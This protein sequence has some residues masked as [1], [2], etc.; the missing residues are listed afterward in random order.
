MGGKICTADIS[1][2]CH[3]AALTL[4]QPVPHPQQPTA[5]VPLAFFCVSSTNVTIGLGKIQQ[6]AEIQE[7]TLYCS[8]LKKGGFL[9]KKSQIMI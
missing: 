9:R 5:A 2:L 7:S 3:C 8:Q 1:V 6:P 4:P